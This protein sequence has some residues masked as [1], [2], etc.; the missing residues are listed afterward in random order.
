M[1]LINKMLQDLD[2]R[3]TPGAGG[4]PDNVRPVMPETS[5]PRARTVAVTAGAAGLAAA[6]SAAAWFGWHGWQG[7]H[8]APAV[9]AKTATPARPAAPGLDMVGK[10]T[11]L[12]TP[13]VGLKPPPGSVIGGAPP[14]APA[15]AAANTPSDAHAAA[16]RAPATA[17]TGRLD[18]LPAR[19]TPAGAPAAVA[20]VAASAAASGAS[21]AAPE[22]EAVRREPQAKKDAQ[23]RSSAARAGR[24]AAVPAPVQALAPAEPDR[25][26]STSQRAEGDYRRALAELQEGRID[27]SV[28]ALQAALRIDPDHEAARQTLV[29]VLVEARRYDEAMREAQLGLTRDPKQPAMAMLLAR[30]QIERGGTGLDTLTRTLPYVGNEPAYHAFLAGALQ[31]QGRQREAAQQY[32]I[33][34]TGAPDNGVWWMGLGVSL[35]ADRRNAEALDAFQ[36]ARAASGLSE[37]LRGFVE[38]Q[39][40]L[41]GR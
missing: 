39:V 41:L 20:A 24:N 10:V 16:P 33:A 37:E 30:L 22:A 13:V 28:A 17:S 11:P 32:R 18:A 2:A 15:D 8:A 3:G 35:Q 12:A 40:A 9:L 14:A 36:K 21:P 5:A 6:L 25:M 38:R 29:G 34:V 23:A 7:R 26:Q 31:R 4:F 19:V 27:G 1:S